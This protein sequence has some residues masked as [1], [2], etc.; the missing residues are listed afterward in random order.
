MKNFIQLEN[1][2]EFV[3]SFIVDESVD[4]ETI[5]KKAKSLKKKF[6]HIKYYKI[7][8]EQAEKYS[9]WKSVQIK[10]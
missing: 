1:N 10:S 7:T 6:T 8:D 4:D 5:I 9:G 2:K 3:D